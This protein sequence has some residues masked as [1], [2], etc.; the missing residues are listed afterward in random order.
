MV[1]FYA[2]TA[3][4]LISKA[5]QLLGTVTGRAAEMG[6]G[7]SSVLA[8]RLAANAT[9]CVVCLMFVVLLDGRLRTG[10]LLHGPSWEIFFSRGVN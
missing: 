6:R 3:P 4:H 1:H 9:S 5:A 8:A 10:L 7:G 2:G